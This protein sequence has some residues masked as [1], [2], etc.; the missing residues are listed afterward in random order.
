MGSK[1]YTSPWLNSS[2][3]DASQ[4]LA[5]ADY[6]RERLPDSFKA[7]TRAVDIQVDEFPSEEIGDDLG[8]ETPFDLLGL[9]EGSGKAKYWTPRSTQKQPTLTLFRRAILDQWAESNEPLGEIITHIVVNEL[10][11]HFGLSDDEIAEIENACH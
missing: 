7:D 9:F 11:H 5:I 8:L 6:V 1:N 4:I 3:P 10:G 2:A